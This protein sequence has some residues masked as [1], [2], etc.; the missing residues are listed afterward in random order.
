MILIACRATN[1]CETRRAVFFGASRT[2]AQQP[3]NLFT[4]KI[5]DLHAPLSGMTIACFGANIFRHHRGNIGSTQNSQRHALH[6]ARRDH[7]FGYARRVCVLGVGHGSREKSG[8]CVGKNLGRFRCFNGGVFHHRLLDCLR[9]KFLRPGGRVGFEKR[10]RA[11][12]VLL[13][14]DL[15][16]RDP[17]DCVGR[18]RR[19]RQVRPAAG[20]DDAPRGVRVPAV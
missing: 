10:L 16:R 11:R 13:P 5:K 19:A 20:G 12:E 1:W 3:R 9:R 2:S 14:A 4:I 6:F 8:Q 18:D 15:R 7:G 17:C